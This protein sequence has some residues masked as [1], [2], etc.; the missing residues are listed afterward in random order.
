MKQAGKQMHKTKLK[1]EYSYANLKGLL[2][3]KITG[4]S[5]Q[6]KI[7]SVVVSALSGSGNVSSSEWVVS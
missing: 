4:V 2:V 7:A 5:L 6:S 3:H 1:V